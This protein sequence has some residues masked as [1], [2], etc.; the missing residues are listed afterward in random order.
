[1]PVPLLG[2]L[3]SFTSGHFSQPQ[4]YFFSTHH[5][6]FTSTLFRELFAIFFPSLR[7]VLVLYSP[8]PSLL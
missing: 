5:S 2:S 4:F 6:L 1:M 3:L 8:E 7:L